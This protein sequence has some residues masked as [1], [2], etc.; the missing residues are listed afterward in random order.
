MTLSK[1]QLEIDRLKWRKWFWIWERDLLWMAAK[2]PAWRPVAHRLGFIDAKIDAPWT[3]PDAGR[4]IKYM[5]N[6]F[7]A[8]VKS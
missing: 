1:A 5:E 7:F 8:E 4:H 2:H 3:F 6:P